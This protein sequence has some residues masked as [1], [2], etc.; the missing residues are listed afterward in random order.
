[1]S[2]RRVMERSLWRTALLEVRWRNDASRPVYP[3]MARAVAKGIQLARAVRRPVYDDRTSAGARGK[4]LT[5]PRSLDRPGQPSVPDQ[6][7][8]P[9]TPSRLRP[10]TSQR[11]LPPTLDRGDQTELADAGRWSKAGLR[12]RLEHLPPGHPSSLRS[13]DPESGDARDLKQPEDAR[14]SCG[15]TDA[16]KQNYWS[17]VPRF[18]RA[19]A[20]HVRRW[21]A[22]RVTLEVDRSRDPGGSWRADSTRYLN[23]DQY[24]QVKEEIGQVR[25][26]QGPLTERI[27]E[28]QKENARGGWL[29]GLDHRLKGG[30]RIKEKVAEILKRMP[31]KD[32][33][34]IVRELPDAIRYTFCFETG[35]Y[36]SGYWDIRRRIEEQGDRMIY[37]KNHWRDDPEY[38][39]INTRWVTPEG[40]MFEVQFHTP[41]SYHAKQEVTH[42]SYERLRSPL[43][44][45]DER[46][47]LRSFQQ[48]VCRWIS[49]PDGA[50]AIPDYQRKGQT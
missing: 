17:E 25:E 36:A 9:E 46:M 22:E 13:D 6:S 23:P 30:D 11:D 1:M 28:V 34:E 2:K 47:E 38:K 21:P 43:T 32:I 45:D 4:E 50:T 3:Q 26:K 33:S 40:Q 20:E 49:V 27:G 24:T 37:S 31:G 35:T 8:A 19:S 12:Q 7:D 44:R 42:G 5:V 18:L 16:I 29:E 10:T 14:I 48:E 39:G 15:E 41:E